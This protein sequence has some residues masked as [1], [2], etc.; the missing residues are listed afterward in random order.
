MI[1]KRMSK[2]ERAALQAKAKLLAEQAQDG[3]PAGGSTSAPKKD[4][5]N[6]PKA[7]ANT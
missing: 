6:E 4:D 2:E 3:Y 7:T 5:K 1:I